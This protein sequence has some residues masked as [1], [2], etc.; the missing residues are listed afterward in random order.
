MNKCLYVLLLLILALVFLSSAPAFAFDLED[1]DELAATSAGSTVHTGTIPT[2]GGYRTVTWVEIDLNA[3]YEVRAMAAQDSFGRRS[4]TLQEFAAAVPNPGED[5]IVFPANFFVTATFE[6]VGGLYSQGRVV[7]AGPQPWLDRGVGFTSDNRMSFF[8]GR[9][10]GSYI[11]GEHWDCPRLPYVT[12]FNAFPH[13][14]NNGARVDIQPIPGATGPWQNALYRRAFMGQRADGIF[15]V[16]VVDGTSIRQLQDIAV[17][18]NLQNATNIDGGASASI[19]RN[20]TTLAAPGRQLASV[21]VIT[22]T[23]APPEP[24]VAGLPFFDIQPGHWSIP[25]IRYVFERGIMNGT[26]AT[27]FAPDANLDRAMVTTVLHRFDGA[28]NPAFRQVFPDV[29]EG[30]WYTYPTIWAYEEGI[31]GGRPDGRFAPQGIITRQELAAMMY[32]YAFVRGHDVSVP[33]NAQLPFLDMYRVNGWAVEYMRWAVYN[34]FFTTASREGNQLNPRAA[35]SRAETAFFVHQF[36]LR[37][38]S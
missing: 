32:R 20:G 6:I 13:L 30:R 19:W 27:A 18:F 11:Y 31:V 38:G 1:M 15:I 14:I 5:T 23:P 12:A 9:F 16:G 33:A 28:G 29:R 2:S 21:M 17:Y 37:F 34:G 4:A 35:A 22:G 10:S 24:P 8:N 3:G 25:A 26:S 7:S 36:S